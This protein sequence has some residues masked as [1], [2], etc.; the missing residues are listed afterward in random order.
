MHPSEHFRQTVQGTNFMTRT[1]VDC[2]WVIEPS[3]T[4]EG[5]SA[6]ITSGRGMDNEPIFGVTISGEIGSETRKL[7][8][9]VY[10]EHQ[11]RDH[12]EFV[13][14]ILADRWSEAM[15]GDAGV[16]WALEG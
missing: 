10:S 1:Y 12:V 3:E 9:L 16:P 2:V 4:E 13:K 8:K 7:S 14:A 11:A 5:V 15:P 6:E